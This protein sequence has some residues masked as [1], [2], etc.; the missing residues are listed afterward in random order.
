MENLSHLYK[1]TKYL[2]CSKCSRKTYSASIN[3]ICGMPQPNGEDCNGIFMDENEPI[4][5]NVTQKKCYEPVHIF[6]KG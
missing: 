3:S 4:G 2:Y 5:K 1:N 6:I